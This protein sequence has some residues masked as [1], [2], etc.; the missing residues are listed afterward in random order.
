[1]SP[2][3]GDLQAESCRLRGTKRVGLAVEPT[4]GEPGGKA[5]WW[6]VSAVRQGPWVGDPLLEINETLK[7]SGSLGS[8]GF[9]LRANRQESRNCKQEGENQVCLICKISL[10]GVWRMR[11]WKAGGWGELAVGPQETRT[12]P[13]QGC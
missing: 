3:E 13:G 2:R 5:A 7:S 1:M 10:A 12:W 6:A 9:V 11:R 8:L 4:L